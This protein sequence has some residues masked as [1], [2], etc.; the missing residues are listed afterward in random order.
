[1]SNSLKIDLQHD[2]RYHHH[3]YKKIIT[4]NQFCW[5]DHQSRSSSHQIESKSLKIEPQLTNIGAALADLKPAAW[6][7]RDPAAGWGAKSISDQNVNSWRFVANDSHEKP[8]CEVGVVLGE[9][10]RS[11][12]CLHRR[13]IVDQHHDDQNSCDHYQSSKTLSPA[14]SIIMVRPQRR[15]RP[16]RSLRKTRLWCLWNIPGSSLLQH[17]S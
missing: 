12:G 4:I 2:H 3:H 1:M 7:K 8:W 13:K 10:D 17:N 11:T 16:Q 9:G 14:V 5:W 15:S 6:T